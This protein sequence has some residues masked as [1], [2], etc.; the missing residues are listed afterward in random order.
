MWVLGY[1]VQCREAR[2]GGVRYGMGINAGMCCIMG[3]AGREVGGAYVVGNA[4][5]N[6]S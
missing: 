2:E 1:K 5:I 6:S 3:G 4:R